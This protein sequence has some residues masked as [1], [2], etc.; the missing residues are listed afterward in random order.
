MTQCGAESKGGCHTTLTLSISLCS[1]D[2]SPYFTATFTGN[3][4]RQPLKDSLTAAETK[5][6]GRHKES[7]VHLCL[8]QGTGLFG[9]H[10]LQHMTDTGTGARYL[11]RGPHAYQATVNSSLA[12][13][14]KSP[15]NSDSAWCCS[16]R[17]RNKC[18]ILQGGGRCMDNSAVHF[19]SALR[20]NFLSNNP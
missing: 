7:S 10:T 18:R 14:G 11:A 3:E 4:R 2:I 13:K 16:L 6:A 5:F 19:S 8:E 12:T 15:K 1:Q 9:H 20:H 17:L